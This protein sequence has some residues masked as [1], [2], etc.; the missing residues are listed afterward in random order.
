MCLFIFLEKSQWVLFNKAKSNEQSTATQS[1]RFV[2]LDRSLCMVF[3]QKSY[4]VQE[5]V[6][7]SLL[8]QRK[9]NLYLQRVHILHYYLLNT[10][11]DFPISYAWFSVL[12]HILKELRETLKT[13]QKATFH[14]QKIEEFKLQVGLALTILKVN[15]FSAKIHDVT[16]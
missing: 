4:T 14:K 7:Y 13:D 16:N 11:F 8:D 12:S 2:L 10:I 6:Q 15:Y 3:T 5:L 1:E 9:A